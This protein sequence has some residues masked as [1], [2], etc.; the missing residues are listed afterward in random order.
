[1]LKIHNIQK[2]ENTY[3]GKWRVVGV[4]TNYKNH[5][6]QSD[7]NYVIRLDRN[8]IGAA[9]IIERI[10]GEWGYNV[11]VCYHEYTN[12]ISITPWPNDRLLAKGNF[13]ASMIGIIDAEDDKK[14]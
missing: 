7:L 6:I 9:I 3:I 12:V 1:M 5:N 8:S 13:F 2:L 11:S 14:K 10:A 4:D